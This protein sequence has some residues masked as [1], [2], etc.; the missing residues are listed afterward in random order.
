[1]LDA[2]FVPVPAQCTRDVGSAAA[3][4]AFGNRPQRATMMNLAR[5][6]AERSALL[7]VGHLGRLHHG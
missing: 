7:A 3:A 6:I 4:P 2:G 1:M 5:P